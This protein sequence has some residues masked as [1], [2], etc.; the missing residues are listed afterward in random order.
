MTARI[1]SLR[2]IDWRSMRFNFAIIFSPGVLD[3]APHTH[4]AAIQAPRGLED[5]IEMDDW[6][7]SPALDFSE[8]EQIQVGWSEYGTAANRSRKK[9]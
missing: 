2:K 1:A 4:V 6:M 9:T 7:I 8:I 5:G 3:K